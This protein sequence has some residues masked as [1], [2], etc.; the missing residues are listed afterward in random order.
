[1][2]LLAPHLRFQSC[3]NAAGASSWIQGANLG[4]S[5]VKVIAFKA[6]AR[7]L[8]HHRYW[9]HRWPQFLRDYLKA[10]GFQVRRLLKGNRW[11]W[12]LQFD[13]RERQNVGE[14]VF[15]PSCIKA[16]FFSVL[17]WAL[18]QLFCC[19]S[20]IHLPFSSLTAPWHVQTWS[21]N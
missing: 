2:L 18:M 12:W 20:C 16:R 17:H 4:L 9:S 3:C 13:V 8:C 6:F 21:W 5:K 7:S 14:L 11:F 19:L 15:L 1:M 10:G